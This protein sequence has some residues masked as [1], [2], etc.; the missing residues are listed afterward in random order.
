MLGQE[1]AALWAQVVQN[2]EIHQVVYELDYRIEAGSIRKPN[3]NRDQE[4]ANSAVQ[5]WG[6]V[7]QTYYQATG[8]P[9]PLNAIITKWALANDE[10]PQNYLLKPPPPPQPQPPDPTE[11]LKI[12]GEQQKQ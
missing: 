2:A 8:D 10:E 4:N 1:R 12:Q 3:R 11:Q 7:L 6:P 5:V 9:N